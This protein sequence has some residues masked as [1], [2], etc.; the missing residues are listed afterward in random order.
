[1]YPRICNF[2]LALTLTLVAATGPAQADPV[3]LPDIGDPSGSAITPQQEHQLGESLVRRMRQEHLVVSDPLLADYIQ[4]L[5]YKLAANADPQPNPFTFFIVKSADINAFAAPGG[6]IGVNYGL[7]LTTQSESELAAVMAHEIAHVTQHHMARTYQAAGRYQWATAIALL[8]AILVGGHND[9][10]G[11]AALAAGIAG[12]A[13]LSIN[14]TRANEKEADAV[15]I[16]ILENSGFDPDAMANFFA[17]MQRAT[18]L[19]GNQLPEFL[20]THPVTG[21]R[22]AEARNRAE[23][24]PHHKVKENPNYYLAKARLRVL[25]ATDPARAEHEFARELAEGSFQNADAEHYGYA[26]A[27]TAGGKYKKASAELAPLLKHSPDRI[28]FLAAQAQLEQASGNTSAALDLF[29]KSLLIYPNNHALTVYYAKALLA[30]GKPEKARALLES[31]IRDRQ[32]DAEVY[33]LYARAAGDAGHLADA[34]Q[35]MAEYY[36]LNGQTHAA[37][38]QLNQA[39]KLSHLDYYQAAQIEARLREFKAIAKQESQ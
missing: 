7:I 10:L 22:I 33:Q 23:Q 25:M 16:R 20:S 24:M 29:N 15:G 27:L 9:Q 5:G 17:R 31:Y 37:I 3:N 30:D 21:S 4:S 8:A 38:D 11:Q 28:F 14:F 26:L 32:P 19:Y 18:R 39:R 2:L 34:Y 12:N 36:F 35:N 13:Q 1:M 6:F